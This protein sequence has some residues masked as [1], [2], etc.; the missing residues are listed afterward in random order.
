MVWGWVVVLSW[1]GVVVKGLVILGYVKQMV[2]E[3]LVLENAKWKVEARRNKGLQ[4]GGVPASRQLK[5]PQLGK[6]S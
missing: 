4:Y 3:Y 5:F 6:W 2:A 1:L